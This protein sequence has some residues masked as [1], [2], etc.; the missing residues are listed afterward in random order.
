[1]EIEKF[2]VDERIAEHRRDLQHQLKHPRS[3]KPLS[4]RENDNKKQVVPSPMRFPAL[5]TR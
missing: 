5:M 4:T 3:V 2:L 1:M